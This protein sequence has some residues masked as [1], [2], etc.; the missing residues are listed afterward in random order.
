[1]KGAYLLLMKLK[2]NTIIPI[3]RLGKIE[4]NKGFYLYAGSALNGLE[5]RILRHTR[6]QKKYHWHIDYFL[7]DAKIVDTFY[8]ESNV[9][10]ECAIAKK[11]DKI[12]PS[13]SEFGCSDCSCNSHLF[14]GSYEEIMNTIDSLKMKQ[15]LINAKY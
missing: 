4:F 1:M 11:L 6:K 13:I 8:K 15:F 5:K 2:N 3:G 12:F 7:N 9:K 10:E 14:Y